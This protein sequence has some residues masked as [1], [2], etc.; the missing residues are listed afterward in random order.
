MDKYKDMGTVVMGKIE[1]GTISEGDSLVVMPNKVSLFSDYSLQ[2]Q[3]FCKIL[4]V[5]GESDLCSLTVLL[6]VNVK[7]ISIYCDEDKVR[8]AAPGENV[9]VK[10]SGIEEEDIA[11]G[12]VLSNI[13]MCILFLQFPSSGSWQDN[14]LLFCLTSLVLLAWTKYAFCTFTALFYVLELLIYYYY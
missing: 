10:L 12:F 1:S 6:K 4:H 2:W 5:L 13:G 9:R 11:A 3:V 14:I 7:V 8:S